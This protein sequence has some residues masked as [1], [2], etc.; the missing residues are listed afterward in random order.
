[1]SCISITRQAG[2]SDAEVQYYDHNQI[3]E[4]ANTRHVK[5]WVRLFLSI[6][7]NQQNQTS[8]GSATQKFNYIIVTVATCL[9]QRVTEPGLSA[10]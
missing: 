7:L 2:L 8:W 9:K 1:M 4:K 10:R 3:I 5:V 6:E